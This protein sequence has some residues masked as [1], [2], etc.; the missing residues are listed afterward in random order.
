MVEVT[1]HTSDGDVTVRALLPMGE[2]V[3]IDDPYKAQAFVR[4]QLE[5]V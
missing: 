5:G 4:R 1:F 3:E 2:G